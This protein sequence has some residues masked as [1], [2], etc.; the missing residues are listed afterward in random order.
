[1][2]IIISNEN[3]T[4]T[5]QLPIIPESLEV[6]FPHNNEVF[7]TVD[8]GDINLIGR[9]GLKSI[10]LS[11]WLPGKE[12][13][14]AKSPLLMYEGKEFFVKYKRTRKPV[15]VVIVNNNGYTYHNELYAIE[16]F[17]FGYDRVGDMPYT[18]VL[19]QFVPSKVI[20]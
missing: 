11:S 20:T 6:A 15:R 7:T 18:L 16:E 17:S 3:R 8:G 4:E 14:F 19:K 13:T 10:T 5:I 2:E 1:M 9:P 12:Y